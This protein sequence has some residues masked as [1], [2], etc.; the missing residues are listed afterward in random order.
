MVKS[1]YEKH[2]RGC[3]EDGLNRYKT[4][5]KETDELRAWIRAVAREAG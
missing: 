2:P 4:G 3:V 1:E 5:R